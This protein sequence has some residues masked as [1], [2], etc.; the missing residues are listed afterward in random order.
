[1]R[2]AAFYIEAGLFHKKATAEEI[3]TILAE[4]AP[5]TVEPVTI[6][7]RAIHRIRLGPFAKGEAAQAAIERIRAAGLK[8]A[9]L[10][11]TQGG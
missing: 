9:R 5:A 1:M 4:I 11:P 6:G 3:A 10:E 2:G 7:E 8:S